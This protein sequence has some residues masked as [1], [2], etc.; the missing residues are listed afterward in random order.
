MALTIAAIQKF[1][2]WTS[3]PKITRRKMNS[4]NIGPNT[5]IANIAMGA[6]LAIA[7]ISA[8]F[9]EP[10]WIPNTAISIAT[11]IIWPMKTKK[12]TNN[13]PHN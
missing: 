2:V 3:D 12:K 13:S 6:P 8:V 10:P 4:S 9:C 11:P 1:V 5:T 7:T